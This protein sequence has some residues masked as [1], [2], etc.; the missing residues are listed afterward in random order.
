MDLL[1][2]TIGKKP[3]EYSIQHRKAERVAPFFLSFFLHAFS[4]IFAGKDLNMATIRRKTVLQEMDIKTNPRTG[5]Q[6][7]FNIT[8]DKLNGERVFFPRAVCC[9]LNMNM[10][11]NRYRGILPVDKNGNSIGHPTPVGIDR[12]IR[13]NGKEVIL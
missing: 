2:R 3:K 5:E 11:A 10:A 4:L 7:V 13:F 6:E 9:G 1:L 12:I 8:F